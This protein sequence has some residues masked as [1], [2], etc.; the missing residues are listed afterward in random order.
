MYLQYLVVDRIVGQSFAAKQQ[1]PIVVFW[2]GRPLVEKSGMTSTKCL[3]V[4]YEVNICARCGR[5]ATPSLAAPCALRT[6][7]AGRGCRRRR[8]GSR[9]RHCGAWENGGPFYT[10]F[11]NFSR[12]HKLA[13]YVSYRLAIGLKLVFDSSLRS[14]TVKIYN[15]VC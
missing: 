3:L 15:G 13:V 6:P 9:M 1:W 7:E 2:V 12:S 11:Q 10:V 8:V 14:K 4:R 5:S